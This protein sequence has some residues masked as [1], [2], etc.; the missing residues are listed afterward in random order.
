MEALIRDGYK[1]VLTG[2]YDSQ[3][4]DVPDIDEETIIR[5]GAV[6]TRCAHIAPESTY[7]NDFEHP[8]SPEKVR[9][10]GFLAAASEFILVQTLYSASF[11]AVLKRFGYDAE[12]L[13]GEKVHS[14]FNVMTMQHDVYYLFDRLELWFEATVS[15]TDI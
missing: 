7:F 8:N 2:K 12:K 4:L 5:V 15:V 14:L 11:L 1:C 6:N 3:A 9:T 13:D 10:Y